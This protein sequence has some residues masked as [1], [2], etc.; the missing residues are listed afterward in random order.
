MKSKTTFRWNIYSVITVPKITEIGQ[1]STIVK[2]IVVGWMVYFFTT[3]CIM[4]IDSSS[5]FFRGNTYYFSKHLV[6]WLVISVLDSCEEG[7]GFRLQPRRCRVT[8]LGKL[9]TPIVPLL[10]KQRNG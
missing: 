4:V 6:M 2:D 8:I 10:T 3:Q 1:L 5:R 9:F 7:S